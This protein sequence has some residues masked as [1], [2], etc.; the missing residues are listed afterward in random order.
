MPNSSGSFSA[1]S[2]HPTAACCSFQADFTTF[3]QGFQAHTIVSPSAARHL[4]KVQLQPAECTE[5][6]LQNP[7]NSH[8]FNFFQSQ[9]DSVHPV[10]AT[11]PEVWQTSRPFWLRYIR[12]PLGALCLQNLWGPKSRHSS[13]II[14]QEVMFNILG[15]AEL[16]TSLRPSR[17]LQEMWRCCSNCSL[18]KPSRYRSHTEVMSNSHH[19][20]TA[21]DLRF[22][23]AWSIASFRTLRCSLEGDHCPPS[24]LVACSLA[25]S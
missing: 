18:G 9:I 7:S 19:S 11:M 2:M 14:T 20:P 22:L 10:R 5:I 1:S 15:I 3:S 8:R 25:Q 13:T 16:G 23:P 6:H 4:R 17:L 24:S 21:P 12:Q